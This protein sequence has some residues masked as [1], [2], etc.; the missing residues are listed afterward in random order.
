M[1][2][3]LSGRLCGF[4]TAQSR[5]LYLVLD[6]LNTHHNKAVKAWAEQNN[7]ELVYTPTYAS[8]LNRIECHFTPLRKFAI[9]NS[10]YSDHLIQ[11]RA[12]QRYITWRNAHRT[13]PKLLK[14]QKKVKVA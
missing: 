3:P 6:N 7:V 4:G 13:D 8:W 2:Q 14:E 5:W 1:L 10:N 9:A 11:N 12:I